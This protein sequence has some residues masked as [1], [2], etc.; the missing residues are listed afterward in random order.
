MKAS[1]IIL[2]LIMSAVLLLG[3]VQ[4]PTLASSGAESAACWSPSRRRLRKN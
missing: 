2:S 4:T 3:G 1:R